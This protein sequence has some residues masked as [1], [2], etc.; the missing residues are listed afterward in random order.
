MVTAK[1]QTVNFMNTSQLHYQFCQLA[2][3]EFYKLVIN[4]GV[5]REEE[6]LHA[7]RQELTA[8]IRLVNLAHH[9]HNHNTTDIDAQTIQYSY[10]LTYIN[11]TLHKFLLR[12]A[13]STR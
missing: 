10:S 11:L 13:N 4:E 5:Q 6:F 9:H 3:S 12:S 1:I 8:C 2:P 7:G